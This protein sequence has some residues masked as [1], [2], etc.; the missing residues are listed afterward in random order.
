VPVDILGQSIG[1]DEVVWSLSS[2]PILDAGVPGNPLRIEELRRALETAG[3]PILVAGTGVI[4]S[5]AWKELREFVELSGIPFYP[6]PQGRGTVPDDHPLCFPSMRSTAFREADLV[7]VVGTRMNYML[8]FGQAPRFSADAVF[9]RIDI[10]ASE[11]ATAP[12]RVDIRTV[13]DCATVLAQL[14][15][16]LGPEPRTGY[17]AWTAQLSE[18]EKSKSDAAAQNAALQNTPVHPLRLCAEVRE[19][20]DRDAILSVDGQEILNFGRQ[21]IPTFEPGHRLNSGPFGMMGVGL[22]LGLGAKV[23]CPD[24]QVIVLHGDGSFGLNGMEV[25]TAVR[26]DIPV[27]IVISNNGG[28]TAIEERPKAGRDLGFTRYDRMVEALGAYGEYV[29]APDEIRPALERAWAE[30]RN[31]RVALVN[32]RTDSTARAVTQRF[33]KMMT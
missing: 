16:A 30:V 13:G 32:V 17:G 23:A 21:A 2:R 3:R 9:A 1:E 5:R 22:P 14:V 31:G 26:L 7:I 24:K 6:T 19:F 28:W 12:R 25:D 8:G 20:M 11:I 10:D 33:T 29:E 4:W 18:G 27:L 15:T